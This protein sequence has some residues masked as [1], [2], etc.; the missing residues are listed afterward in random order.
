MSTAPSPSRRLAAY[1][2]AVSATGSVPT[3][4]MALPA[5]PK[6][7]LPAAVRNVGAAA[8]PP[9]PVPEADWTTGG[10]W[11][12]EER[13][14]G[15]SLF[16]G[17]WSCLTCRNRA[18]ASLSAACQH[19]LSKTD[20]PGHPGSEMMKS[21]EPDFTRAWNGELTEKLRPGHG[22]LEPPPPGIGSLLPGP[23]GCVA[24]DSVYE[25][26][27]AVA[28]NQGIPGARLGSPG[29]R[30]GSPGAPIGGALPP[31][32]REKKKRILGSTAS[33]SSAGGSGPLRKIRRCG[34]GP[35]W[36]GWACEH[37]QEVETE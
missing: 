5:D 9:P 37:C 6:E 13:M 8:L 4:R 23:D 30:L 21:W 35:S 31:P 25:A 34:H 22:P 32:T 11:G 20:A 2:A 36:I 29:A 15:G 12:V 1:Q 28:E 33:G 26:L 7:A 18:F 19:L 16:I 3:L 27:D 24:L 17:S 14:W 10:F